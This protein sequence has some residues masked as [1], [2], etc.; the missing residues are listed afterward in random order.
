[1]KKKNRPYFL[2]NKGNALIIVLITIVILSTLILGYLSLTF[3]QYKNNARKINYISLKWAATGA[4][5][6]FL[7]DVITYKIFISDT[8]IEDKINDCIYT[9]KLNK[10]D[11]NNFYIDI[12]TE[13][14]NIKYQLLLALKIKF[15]SD[16]LFYIKENFY[17][18]P[19]FT[20]YQL[21]GSLFIEKN[22]YI[23]TQPKGKILF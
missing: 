16:Y 23:G 4:L 20:D 6:K 15:L 2:N 12:S 19:S 13:K 3:C 5:N 9:L 1:M 17:I 22:L 21:Y 7:N 18:Y 10:N 8:L 14:Q 11:N